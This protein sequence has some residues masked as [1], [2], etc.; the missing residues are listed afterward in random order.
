MFFEWQLHA[1]AFTFAALAFTAFA[2]AVFSVTAEARQ[3]VAA[4]ELLG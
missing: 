2:F 3:V 4:A 1:T